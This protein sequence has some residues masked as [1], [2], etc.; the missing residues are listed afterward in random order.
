M[1]LPSQKL[2]VSPLKIG[3]PKSN[4]HLPTLDFEGPAICSL[5]R[6]AIKFTSKHLVRRYDWTTFFLP[7]TPFTS[8]GIGIV[9]VVSRATYWD[10]DYTMKGNPSLVGGFNPFEKY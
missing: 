5:F 6:R 3:H 4:V 9:D 2:T 8:G 1:G 10:V 7:K